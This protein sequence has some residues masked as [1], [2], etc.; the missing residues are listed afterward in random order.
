M[1]KATVTCLALIGLVLVPIFFFNSFSEVQSKAD[2]WPMFHHDLERTGYS[3]T[4]APSNNQTLWKFNTGGQVGS[5]T[6]VNGVVYVGSY[7]HKIYAFNASTGKLLW[8]YTTGDMI[9]TSSPAVSNGKVFIGSMDGKVYAL[10]A[11]TG[12]PT[13]NHTTGN[14]VISSPTVTNA[15]VYVGSYD[16]KVYVLNQANGAE[17]W[18]FST[19]G[20]VSSSPAIANGIV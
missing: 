5:P 15:L 1:K 10:N 6:V 2:S 11:S 12:I 18:N 14:I 3:E 8:N 9:I 7:D 17:V 20:E 16:N 4:T 19:G 13:W